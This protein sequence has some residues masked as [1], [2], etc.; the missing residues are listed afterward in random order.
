MGAPCGRAAPSET[1]GISEER[2]G[3]ARRSRE[4]L[5]PRSSVAH[6]GVRACYPRSVQRAS[7][8]ATRRHLLPALLFR[9]QGGHTCT[10]SF[11]KLFML[12]FS[13]RISNLWSFAPHYVSQKMQDGRS[14]GCTLEAPDGERL[15]EMQQECVAQWMAN[16]SS[17]EPCVRYFSGVASAGCS[18]AG[19][20][21]A[22]RTASELFT[23]GDAERLCSGLQTAHQNFWPTFWSA[24]GH[25]RPTAQVYGQGGAYGNGILQS[26]G[27]SALPLGALGRMGPAAAQLQ[28]QPHTRLERAPS[29]ESDFS[30]VLWAF[31]RRE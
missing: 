19:L 7:Y 6:P 22:C 4:R 1:D 30:D 9:R 12:R 3:E 31:S 20:Q 18:A 14:S 17:V 16:M 27:A 8:L 2:F 29:R 13:L 15:R 10:S 28:S 21:E 24:S 26:G 5:V 23:V 25:G 11:G